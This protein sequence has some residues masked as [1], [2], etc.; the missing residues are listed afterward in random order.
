MNKKKIHSF[1]KKFVAMSTSLFMLGDL[2]SPCG[3]AV[4]LAKEQTE[5]E[6][7]QELASQRDRY[8]DGAFAFYG[9][10]GT[11]MT[12]GEKD[13]EILVVRL[14]DA[15]KEATVDLKCMDVTAA[16]GEDYEVYVLENGKKQKISK[17]YASQT[18]VEQAI[19]GGGDETGSKTTESAKETKIGQT[20]KSKLQ[21]SVETQTG[22]EVDQTGWRQELAEY[23]AKT[24]S[25]QA[26]NE[27]IGSIEGPQT[28]IHFQE[29]E[30]KKT[31]YVHVN[32][33]KIAECDEAAVL[34][35][36]NAS[37][38]MIGTQG[39]HEIQIKDNEEAEKITFAL[40]QSEVKVE[41]NAT[42]AAVTIQRLSGFGYYA[43]A[44]YQTAAGTAEANVDYEAVNGGTVSFAPGE[45]EK[46]VMIP[47]C[48]GA[49]EGTYL[50]VLLDESAVNV[51]AGKERARVWIGDK[52]EVKNTKKVKASG[53]VRAKGVEQIDG[54][55]YSTQTVTSEISAYIHCKSD[56][57]QSAYASGDFSE[58][59]KGASIVR[60]KTQL[61]G[62][63][64]NGVIPYYNKN[65]TLWLGGSEKIHHSVSDKKENET[66][67]YDD[68]VNVS[69]SEAQNGTVKVRA[70]TDG[71]CRDA[72]YTVK[73]TK[74]YYPRYTVKLQNAKQDL[75]GKEYTATDQYTEF[76]VSALQGNASW[77]T[78]TVDRDGSIDLSPGIMTDGVYVKQYDI[79]AGNQ[80]IG[81][82]S[83]SLSYDT[84]DA[85]RS[86]YSDVLKQ[87][88]YTITIKPVYAVNSATVK[89]ES[90]DT[91]AVAF[92]GDK[93]ERGFKVGDT[94]KCTQIDKVK[95]TATCPNDHQ[96]K[97]SSVKH[98]EERSVWRW[99]K[100]RL[101][102]TIERTKIAEYTPA[103]SEELRFTKS[104]EINHEKEFITVYYQEPS[105]TVECDQKECEDWVDK[106]SGAV[107]IANNNK[108]DDILGTSNYKQKFI[109]QGVNMFSSDYLFNVIPGEQFKNHTADENRKNK[110]LTTKTRWTYPDPTNPKL[111]K[112][113]TGNLLKFTPRYADTTVSYYFR[114]ETDD[115]EQVGIEGT[116]CYQEKP[117][118]IKNAKENKTPA[119]GV[120]VN[121]GGYTTKTG[122]DGKYEIPA[123]FNKGEYVG[124]FISKNTLSLT[125]NV[126]M[127]KK[128]GGDFEI[129]VNQA[130][131]L[132]VTS[133]EMK[134]GVVSK[135]RDMSNNPIVTWKDADGVTL[136]DGNYTF[137]L[138]AQGKPG[139]T[140]AKAKFLF[141]SK[142]GEVKSDLTQVVSFDG[143]GVAQLKLNPMHVGGE[144]G[145]SLEVGDGMTV[146]LI[147]QNGKEY[148][149]HQTG[150]VVAEKLEGMCTFNY[151]GI[152]AEDDN[153]FLK[154][155]GNISIGYDF[156]IDML[157]NDAGT[158]SDETG[159]MHQLMCVGFGEG[160]GSAEDIY[161]TEQNTI[162]QLKQANS[163][164]V[165][166]KKND[167]LS[168]A[169][170]GSWSL[171]IQVGAI[172][173]CVVETEDIEKKGQY[174]FS[175][176]VLIG[177][178]Q[179]SYRKEWDTK[180]GPVALTFTLEFNVGDKADG[181]S[182]GIKW[183]FYNDSEK[184][185]FVKKND[186]F[187]LLASEEI[188]SQG[189]IAL[190]ARILGG[191]EAKGLD[192]IGVSGDLKVEFDHH[193]AHD[194]NNGWTNSGAII[195]T[196]TVKLIIA[197]A[198][199]PIWTQ[200]WRFDYPKVSAQQ[201]TLQ[202]AVEQSFADADMMHVSTDTKEINDYS[203]M[204]DS[205]WNPTGN[206]K[207]KKMSVVEGMTQQVLKDGFYDQSDLN[208]QDLGDGKYLAVFLDGVADRDDANKIGAYYTVFDGTKWSAPQL[209]E[210]DGTADELP[211][212]C[213]AGSKGYLVVWSDASEKLDADKNMSDNLNLFNLTGCFYNKET[214]V[215]GEVM[216]ITRNTKEDTV[217]DT[218]PQV[219]YEKTGDRESLRIY[220]TKSEYSVSNATE[221]EVVGDLLNPYQVVAVRTYDF[222]NDKW[223]EDFPEAFETA[224][225]K[226][227]TEEEFASYKENWYGQEF[228][229]LAPALQ[230][231]EELDEDGYW[232]EG[233][234][235]QVTAQGSTSAMAKGGDVIAYNQLNLHAYAL[236]KGGN[237][238]T[239]NDQN[240]YLQIY[241]VADGEYHHPIQ[242]TSKDAEIS[243]I[244]FI[245][246]SVPDENG[247][248]QE[249]TYL[250]WLEDGIVKRI[251]VS[252]MV[253]SLKK[254]TTESG[255]S[256]YYIDKTKSTEETETSY[257]PEEVVAVA[258]GEAAED[259]STQASITSYQVKQQGQ[260]NYILWTQLVPET[261][262]EKQTMES[263]LYAV[264]ENTMT[265]D[266]SQSV[267]LTDQS[268]LYV[269]NFDFSVTKD[270]NLDVLAEQRT[271]NA[272][273]ELTA[274]TSKLVSYHVVPAQK[275][276][277]QNV[278]EGGIVSNQED[279]LGM[280][281][282][283][284]VANDSLRT[285]EDLVVEVKDKDGKV[286]Y[287]SAAA[288][289]LYD[290]KETENEDGTV[291]AELVAREDA[292]V[293]KLSLCGGEQQ[294][295]QAVVPLDE[296]YGYEGTLIL[297][298]G[299]KVL[300]EKALSG[301]AQAK[302]SGSQ[303]ASQVVER[304]HILLTGEV[305]NT[306]PIESAAH[307]ATFGYQKA[308]GTKVKLG[309]VDVP[310]L[311]PL[312]TTAVEY[313]AQ[314]DFDSF[315]SE[316]QA[317]GSQ[318]AAMTFYMDVDAKEFVP[319]YATEELTAS[320]DQMTLMKS[321]KN[322]S[323]KCA[324][325]NEDAKVEAVE[326]F[327]KGDVARLELTVDGAFA[328][329]TEEYV[330]G[331]KVLWNETDNEVVKLSE[332][333]VIEAKSNGSTKVSGYIVP[334]DT[335]TILYE[336]G[337]SVSVNSF[338]TMPKEAVLPIEV[339]VEVKSNDTA[340]ATETPTTTDKVQP[341]QQATEQPVATT[342]VPQPAETT[343]V[344][345]PS[346][347]AVQP[348]E[349]AAPTALKVG[350]VV[351]D[352]TSKC[353]FKVVKGSKGSNEVRCIKYVGTDKAVTIP[354]AIEKDGV[355]YKV[356]S[357][358]AKAFYK[359][360]KITK[361]TI[362]N[363]VTTVGSKAFYGCKNLKTV[364]VKAENL[365][366]IG[367]K[368]FGGIQKKAVFKVPKKKQAAYKKLLT[369]KTGYKKTMKLKKS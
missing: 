57:D 342:S 171:D 241:N 72:R 363:Q 51:K 102:R 65:G 95:F 338:D 75:K 194:T 323:A 311:Q 324:V 162:A 100:W 10:T 104:V 153:L 224:Y 314:I 165:T 292:E 273:G 294:S 232:K 267:Q 281:V 77:N 79:Y 234:Q 169:G 322:V 228:L 301:T 28:T 227:H 33:D 258:K 270:G 16:Y 26:E 308:D 245:R 237:A 212:I 343:A 18:A 91:S 173:D 115:T 190:N 219:A 130:E 36:G 154:A 357:I 302:L 243:D 242:I 111:T 53:M 24:A 64:K 175:D 143:N 166:P 71:L 251:N 119:V 231:T 89:F 320:A 52:A 6:F 17:K 362:P 358:A 133:S 12:E 55:T 2:I 167:S 246:S 148:F 279:T 280:S 345:Q 117:L 198:K 25:I 123:K 49:R 264:C 81:Q 247:E 303:F 157:A 327:A 315:Y 254:G 185:F 229:D 161:K 340:Q 321:L 109:N 226:N 197:F 174:K 182:L 22:K 207:W 187:D 90:Q 316:A 142:K 108:P 351:K 9:K 113:I 300:D 27:L 334:A 112:T 295:L 221:G 147:D 121:V 335:E 156:I 319:V 70:N 13:R 50:N 206:K 355:Q 11:N 274:D 168:F 250:Y 62:K 8:P 344:P 63:S 128:T 101:K 29:G 172:L 45:K 59:S 192:L 290:L 310:A 356:T 87:N 291:T 48:K 176:Y 105:L 253:Q 193:F 160:F 201:N 74:F 3:Q 283:F 40:K 277:L 240:L 66:R 188:D 7:R 88:K 125:D 131:N 103:E 285:E 39:Q 293:P 146:T 43:S 257:S 35:L 54:V 195:L 200:D 268:D 214:G 32:D 152:K 15:D 252:S 158:Y 325:T 364:I 14:G 306:S 97:V 177:D 217:S 163:V 129:E 317:D 144:N 189:D 141:Y 263:H 69:Y 220:Y 30:Y 86:S 205:K 179:A 178:V 260:Y 140:P 60:F 107:T 307:T 347:T 210:E 159:N 359:N 41:K 82:G 199:I 213:D 235:A 216:E 261:D 155:L 312:E 118:F 367:A 203:Y 4:A 19:A 305:T 138:Q 181:D 204:E 339:T 288:E 369:V 46:K 20:F 329:N 83:S 222:A 37:A 132:T 85:L 58:Y 23:E 336:D 333:G 330:N 276:R 208:V 223:S 191:V 164:G 326:S 296:Q 80:R 122:S 126:A 94:L 352:A 282:S 284:D 183:H 230:L 361:V 137:T 349:T 98:E 255:Q 68:T 21:Q 93:G 304:D 67:N 1:S 244:Q 256:Y 31:V 298:Q 209:L 225:K 73:E 196:P 170:N 215:M 124:V 266:M 341:T 259:G 265:G 78:K 269:G 233:T 249:V 135:D 275:V 248:A 202:Q 127:S 289:T 236:D 354:A 56:L 106:N 238:Q 42:G 92:S 360:T 239:T 353:N 34:F 328:Q 299:D 116:V 96:V 5:E 145:K 309:T 331:V 332:S 184:D 150:I 348:Q 120:D 139:V 136:E 114:D 134:R 366:T 365:K 44:T 278:T 84:L 272:D 61:T 76:T 368:A 180:V 110:F 211:V 350:T 286:V 47:L 297:R 318:I 337:G 346:D 99:K 186:I 287:T 262:N 151:P 313:E 218:A 271:L 38:G 149:E